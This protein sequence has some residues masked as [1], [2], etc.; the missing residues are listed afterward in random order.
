M[1][2]EGEV[3]S[4]VAP[5]NQSNLDLIESVLDVLELQLTILDKAGF[6]MASICLNDAIEKLRLN[7]IELN[8]GV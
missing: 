7:R 1:S 6:S 3:T 8:R 5:G 4:G 2:S